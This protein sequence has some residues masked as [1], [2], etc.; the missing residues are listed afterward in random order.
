MS[1]SGGGYRAH[2]VLIL[3]TNILLIFVIPKILRYFQGY[4]TKVWVSGFAVSTDLFI[5]TL[6]K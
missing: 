6:T 1:D 5:S 3:T 2:G 4:S